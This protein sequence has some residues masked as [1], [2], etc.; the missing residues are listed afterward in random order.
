MKFLLLTNHLFEYGGSEV[1]IL[2]L[3]AHLKAQ[4][5]TAKIYANDWGEAFKGLFDADDVLA[6]IDAICVSDYDVVWVQHA[7]FARLFKDI[8]QT[9]FSLKVISVHLSPYVPLEISSLA[10]MKAIGA[11]FVVNSAETKQK[12][13]ELSIDDKDIFVSHNAAPTTFIQPNQRKPELAKIA[14]VSNHPPPRASDSRQTA[15]SARH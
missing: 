3:Y 2:E 10:Y 9:D 12:L 6:D 15:A 11:T 13:T 7:I 1:Q 5:H 8:K 4:N 14:I